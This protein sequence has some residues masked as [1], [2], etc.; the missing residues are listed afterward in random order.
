M[1][2]ILAACKLGN[3]RVLVRI[4]LFFTNPMNGESYL[5]VPVHGTLMMI[6]FLAAFLLLR[7][8]A[9]R[10]GISQKIVSDLLMVCMLSGVLG[11]RIFFAIQNGL[12]A[13]EWVKVWHGGL[14][15]YDGL[16]GAMIFG[17]LFLWIA[18]LT[19]RPAPI[20]KIMDAAAPATMLGL[21]FGRIGCFLNGCCW[22]GPVEGDPWWAVRYIN[23]KGGP[24][25]GHQNVLDAADLYS[26]P[27]HPAQLYSATL[28]LVICLV[29]LYARRWRKVYGEQ[30]LLMFVLYA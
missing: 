30:I 20:A 8:L 29:L 25:A 16:F 10:D 19:N 23:V 3:W 7:R 9:K 18:K 15:W 5:E 4:P 13:R 6:G 11:A 1:T 21:V 28:V 27:L 26:V 24:E 2:S 14:V 17:A 22:G 12:P